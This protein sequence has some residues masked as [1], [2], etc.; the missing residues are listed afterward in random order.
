EERERR[1]GPV[2]PGAG[3]KEIPGQRRH[4]SGGRSAALSGQGLRRRGLHSFSCRGLNERA[5]DVERVGALPDLSGGPRGRHPSP[6]A[7]PV[8]RSA[9]TGRRAL[10]GGGQGRRLA[11]WIFLSR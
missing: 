3:G 5:A 2:T 1:G 6:R 9:S 11:S 7:I 8:P 4:P 10:A